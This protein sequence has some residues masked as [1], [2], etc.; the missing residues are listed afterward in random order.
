[1]ENENKVYG[2]GRERTQ[3]G[4][5]TQNQRIN[6]F[7]EGGQEK[8]GQEEG[9]KEEGGQEEGNKEEGG[10]EEGSEEEGGQEVTTWKCPIPDCSKNRLYDKKGLSNHIFGVH[11]ISGFIYNINQF[12]KK[13][14]NAKKLIEEAL[15]FAEQIGDLKNN[16]MEIITKYLQNKEYLKNNFK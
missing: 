8:G 2:F 6:P 10:Q 3:M 15:P 14:E 5:Q 16:G 1:M 13:I 12:N 7:D 4:F 11:G 9:G